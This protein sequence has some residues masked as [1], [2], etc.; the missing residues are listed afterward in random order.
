MKYINA[1]VFILYALTSCSGSKGQ[2]KDDL[3][4]AS[5]QMPALTKDKAGNIHVVYGSGDSILYSFSSTKAAS[6]SRPTLITVLPHAYTFATR[7]PQIA[8]TENGLVVTASTS[9][10][11]I[12][13][14]YKKGSG[15]WAEGAKVNDVDTIAK[16]GLMGLT[17]DGDNVFAAWLDL[18]GNKKNKIYSARSADG[19]KT[20]LKNVLVY[21]SPDTTV[22]ECCKPSVILKENNVYVM[23]RNWLGGNRDMYLAHSDN[24][25]TS[26]AQPQKLGV[27][28]WKLEGCPMDGGGIALNKSGEVQSVWRR[29]D[30]IFSTTPGMPEKEIGKGKTCTIESV[31][32]KNVYAWVEDGNIVV[33][34][35][36]GQKKILGKGGQPI[37]KAINNEHVLCV[38]ENDKQ[39]HAS[40]M[41]L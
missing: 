30:K 19:G 28:S 21:A 24:G 5:G 6:F 3:T 40:V 10:G 16:E 8:T 20:W 9:L 39:I 41:E 12:H 31:N 35:P 29:E 25:G 4:V 23:F 1:L 33:L 13:S 18:R 22:C 26:F 17:S 11:D 34:K 32:N 14:F 27:G 2:I 36:R 15:A 37:L 38:W 7:G